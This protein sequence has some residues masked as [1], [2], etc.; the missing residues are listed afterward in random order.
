MPR[1]PNFQPVRLFDPDFCYK[2]AYLMANSA[3][4]DQL[5]SSEANWSGSTLFAKQGIS[6]LSRTRVKLNFSKKSFRN[7]IRVSNS[8]DPDQTRSFQASSWSKLF[9]KVISRRQKS[10]LAEKELSPA[11]DNSRLAFD[12]FM[13]I[14]VIFM[15]PPFRRIVEGD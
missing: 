13:A 14:L 2:F 11:D 4:P 12:I 1:P 9:V 8:L 5:A 6:W 15:P 10:A 7:I 3:D